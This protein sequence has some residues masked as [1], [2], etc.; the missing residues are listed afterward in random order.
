MVHL[1]SWT[2]ASGITEIHLMVRVLVWYQLL[3]DL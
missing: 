2:N 1:A 3:V